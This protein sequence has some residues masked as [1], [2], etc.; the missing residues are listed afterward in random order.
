MSA[1][2]GTV[3]ASA[4][5]GMVDS[6]LEN[7]L[8]EIDQRDFTADDFIVISQRLQ[9]IVLT[10]HGSLS[11]VQQKSLVLKVLRRVAEHAL[12]NIHDETARTAI[13]LLLMMSD[14]LFDALRAAF[15]KKFDLNQDG[16]VSAEEFNAVCR[17]C[18]CAPRS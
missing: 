14:T 3:P 7:I 8:S 13:K 4:L 15:L 9:D 17:G 18:C 2:A 11:P 6:L 10:E 1:A 12:V 5:E 16:E